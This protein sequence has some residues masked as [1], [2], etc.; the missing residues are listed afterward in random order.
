MNVS[1]ETEEQVLKEARG[2]NMASAYCLVYVK[3]DQLP[4]NHP[5]RTYKLSSESGY[6]EDIYS[7]LV[8][9]EIKQIIQS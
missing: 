1:E 5:S 4:S 6:G 2:L 7:S 3:K 8:P 9:T